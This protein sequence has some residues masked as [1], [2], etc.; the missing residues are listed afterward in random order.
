MKRFSK[1]YKLSDKDKFIKKAISLS[2]K[3]SDFIL[4]N[5][6]NFSDTYDAIIAYDKLSSIKSINNSLNTYDLKNEIEILN[7]NNIDVFDLPNV[8]F[9]QPKTI[10]LIKNNIATIISI[11]K[12]ALIND[13]NEIISI[14]NYVNENEKNNK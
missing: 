11:N 1:S 4:L 10:W 2:K 8:Y 6:N 7:E 5:S 12:D 14:T 13:W 9:F 3:K